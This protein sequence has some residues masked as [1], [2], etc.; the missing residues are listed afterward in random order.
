MKREDVSAD[1]INNWLGKISDVFVDAIDDLDIDTE[2][3]L[4]GE[5]EDVISRFFNYPDYR[6][7][8]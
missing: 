6:N 1:D 2:D 3:E 5:I 8:N 7:Y 4:L